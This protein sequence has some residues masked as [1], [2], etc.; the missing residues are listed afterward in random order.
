MF[1]QKTAGDVCFLYLPP[2]AP[3]GDSLPEGVTK[4]NESPRPVWLSRLSG[5]PE[6]KGTVC[7][8]GQARARVSG[9]VP[10]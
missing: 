4:V 2:S 7:L 3:G 6:P 5:V 9:W 1:M 8:P 10:R